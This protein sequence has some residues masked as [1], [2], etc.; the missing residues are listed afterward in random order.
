MLQ[1]LLFLKRRK[2]YRQLKRAEVTPRCEGM[3]IKYKRLFCN[4]KYSSK[5]GKEPTK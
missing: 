1:I 3:L 2:Y 4:K 5:I